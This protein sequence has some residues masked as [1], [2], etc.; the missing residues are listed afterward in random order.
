MRPLKIFDTGSII[1]ESEKRVGNE[2]VLDCT[3][4]LKKTK[5]KAT[6]KPTLPT[7]IK[8]SLELIFKPTKRTTHKIVVK[9]SCGKIN[10]IS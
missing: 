6:I 2:G 1:K 8:K 7:S 5:T 10:K 4:G 3:V 9:I